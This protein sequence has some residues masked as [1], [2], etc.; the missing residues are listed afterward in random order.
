MRTCLLGR[1]LLQ[2]MRSLLH[3]YPDVWRKLHP[4]TTDVFTVWEVG[5]M[6]VGG[7]AG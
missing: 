3:A 2:L 4:D 7:G 1:L 6:G 5:P